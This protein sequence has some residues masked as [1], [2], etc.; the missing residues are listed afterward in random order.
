MIYF[1]VASQ[2]NAVK[3]GW[4]KDPKGRVAHL[5]TGHHEPLHLIR[6][7]EGPR[8][9]E[10]WLHDRFSNE[11]LQG[12]WF[13]FSPIMLTVKPEAVKKQRLPSRKRRRR[14]FPWGAASYAER[15]EDPVSSWTL[16]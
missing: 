5:Q 12:E 7:L 15:L 16:T 9:W 4:S 3:I 2:S 13:R 6:T 11:W 1:I 8:R 14:S 10:R